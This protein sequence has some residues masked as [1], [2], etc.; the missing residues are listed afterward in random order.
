MAR[1]TGN[2]HPRRISFAGMNLSL[3]DI[4]FSYSSKAFSPRRVLDC[5]NLSVQS[6]ECVAI[7]GE[8]GAG[9]STLLQL[10]NGLLKPDSGTVSVDGDDIWT[11]PRRQRK[12]RQ[13][14][15][16]AFQFPEQQ[17]FCETVFDELLFTSRN[18]GH[19]SDKTRED[20]I[21]VLRQ[22]G[23]DERVL[24][25]SPFSLSMG[26]ARRVALAS[27]LVHDPQVFL[28]DEPTAGLDGF[29]MDIVMSLFARL[30]SRGR[31][32]VFASHE[33]ELISRVASRVAKLA[34][35]NLKSDYRVTES[36]SVT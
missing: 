1:L 26:E 30:K 7:V 5:I 24:V 22:L 3:V 9:K 21:E 32:I 34:E 15:G 33:K 2:F 29:G 23:L 18:M 35:G 13:N 14:V 11:N 12:M 6:G 17:F 20:C 8:E 27:L 31:T 28:L 25:R 16:F 19:K 4:S 36:L 10:M